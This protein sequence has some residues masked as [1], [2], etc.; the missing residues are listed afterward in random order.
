MALNI[1]KKTAFQKYYIETTFDGVGAK[2]VYPYS[3]RNCDSGT[4]RQQ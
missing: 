3:S 4:V 2:H 1:K